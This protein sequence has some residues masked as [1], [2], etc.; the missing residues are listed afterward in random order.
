MTH[1]KASESLPVEKFEI[2]SSLEVSIYYILVIL[3]ITNV[4]FVKIRKFEPFRQYIFSL[5]PLIGVVSIILLIFSPHSMI[6]NPSGWPPTRL[7]SIELV[8]IIAII[9][10]SLFIINSI[11]QIYLEGFMK[12]YLITSGI[13]IGA[14]ILSDFIHESGHAITALLAGGEITEFYPFPVLL[15]GEFAAGYVTFSNVPSSLIPLILLGGE[16]FQ[17]ITICVLLIFFYINPK[18]R[19]NMF[20]IALLIIAF[21]DF[22]LYVINNSMGLPHW[23]LIGST[24]GDIIIFSDLT[25]FPL[26]ALILIGCV[27]LVIMILIFYILLFRNREKNTKEA[28]KLI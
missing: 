26:W 17:W 21:L 9:L 13:I 24:R 7:E 1:A 28:S 6:L 20:L 19:R 4:L 15:G 10:F 8:G 18:Y 22:P 25:N 2:Y 27:Q 11:F 23:F 3:T 16:I 12:K 14:L 5:T